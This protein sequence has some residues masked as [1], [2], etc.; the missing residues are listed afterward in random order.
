MLLWND[1][2]INRVNKDV[3]LAIFTYLEAIKA[4]QEVRTP[5]KDKLKGISHGKEEDNGW[6]YTYKWEIK[7]KGKSEYAQQEYDDE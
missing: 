6:K 7:G 4:P 5:T 3:L 1:T 2:D